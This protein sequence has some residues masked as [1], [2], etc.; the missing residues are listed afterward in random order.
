MTVA[1]R[2]AAY[3]DAA[4]TGVELPVAV[5]EDVVRAYEREVSEWSR[6]AMERAAA[7]ARARREAEQQ[8]AALDRQRQRGEGQ[9]QQQHARGRGKKRGGGGKRGGRRRSSSSA[10]P[11]SSEGLATAATATAALAALA[12]LALPDDAPA[13][14]APS[15]P[16][17]MPRDP[18]FARLYLAR[19]ARG[20]VDRVFVDHPLYGASPVDDRSPD[21]VYTY[22]E[23]GEGVGMVAGS[24]GAPDL[25]A[26]YS[27]LCQA[28]LAAPL[29]LWPRGASGGA[30]ASYSDSLH[31]VPGLT[32][33]ESATLRALLG[34]RAP[35]EARRDAH[36]PSPELP[37]RVV[38][39]LV[40]VQQQQQEAFEEE[41]ARAA[42]PDTRARV[43]AALLDAKAAAR[44]RDAALR[45]AAA[46][47]AAAAAADEDDNEPPRQ[48]SASPVPTPAP[49]PEG[50]PDGYDPR[51]V[52]V[53][54][55][56]P[57]GPLPHW[58][59]AYREEAAAAAAPAA[60]VAAAAAAPDDDAGPIVPPPPS[61]PAAAAAAS[62]D[63]PS[64]GGVLA[65]ATMTTT[66]TAAPQ[67]AQQQQQQQQPPPRR[68]APTTADASAAA[69][70]AAAAAAATTAATP[71][72][73]DPVIAAAPAVGSAKAAGVPL[74]QP[75]LQQQQQQQPEQPQQPQQQQQQQSSPTAATEQAAD[76]LLAATS[77]YA[78]SVFDPR[79]AS[80]VRATL[81][82]GESSTSSQAAAPAPASPAAAASQQQQQQQQ[83][84]LLRRQLA[85]DAAEAAELAAAEAELGEAMARLRS[86][87]RPPPRAPSPA[88]AEDD[89]GE[90]QAASAGASGDDAPPA[91]E[92]A[93]PAAAAPASPPPPPPPPP[94]QAVQ[95]LFGRLLSGA[96]VVMTVHNGGYQGDFG[97]GPA[98]DVRRLG[99]PD[100]AAPAFGDRPSSDSDGAKGADDP[101]AN[102]QRALGRAMDAFR[103]AVRGLV[104][105]PAAA[106]VEEEEPTAAAA[107]E[108]EDEQQ[109]QQQAEAPPPAPAPR[110]VNWLRG[111]LV[112]GDAVVTVSPE[113]AREMAGLG[114]EAA[115]AG[116]AAAA[117]SDRVG[118]SGL[119]RDLAAALRARGVAGIL[120]GLDAEA[121]DPSTDPLLPAAARFSP[122]TAAAGKAAAKQLLRRRLGLAG[123]EE[124]KGDLA[125]S[126][127]PLVAYV[128]R[129]ESQK[130]VD[131][132]LAALPAL[133][134]DG[135]ASGEG[136]GAGSS[137]STSTSTSAATP[138]NAAPPPSLQLVML[139]R[140]QPWMERV[141]ASLARRYPGKAAGLA[142]FSEPLA[143]LVLAAADFVVVP[144]RFEPCG[145]VAL[146]AL[147]YGCPVVA[148]RTGGLVD[149]VTPEVGYPFD[150]PPSA[151]GQQ[152]E[153]AQEAGAAPDFRRAVAALASSVTGAVAEYGTDAYSSRRAAGMARAVSW[154][155]GPALQWEALLADVLSSSSSA[156]AEG[157]PAAAPPLADDE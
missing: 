36:R 157:G 99:L 126:S 46:S 149:I 10:S 54:N 12:A 33:D 120:N 118:P 3:A 35:G 112:A 103:G 91:A 129:F 114:S 43:L 95:R 121:W 62:P 28:A 152:Q 110:G 80:M 134:G 102:A 78:V 84:L 63:R 5:P 108:E 81:A 96:R 105:G 32:D 57:C 145:L 107:K 55:D 59:D 138:T 20:R 8:E 24:G 115:A 77:D 124:E 85:A 60:P 21:R 123:G 26:A 101:L 125:S 140:G 100:K 74:S 37:L 133:L 61:T 92:P 72:L 106:E 97:T 25:A 127:V 69:A 75:P 150:A 88:P 132:L 148:A 117:S 66:T 143:H 19:D 53:G 71:E 137:S 151:A 82:E 131:V 52:F 38:D 34:G 76:A 156:A 23:A 6:G 68:A 44:R 70:N 116:W 42:S 17:P 155:E 18:R 153:S 11:S 50:E 9:Q 83:Q 94:L 51:I 111:G 135:A 65:A 2:Y 40:V 73:D 64:D 139:G 29:L 141:V 86:L 30:S 122:E 147:R 1:P 142:E 45:L 130:G 146:A 47:P 128:G 39:G 22:L 154:Q 104:G 79:L 113:Y 4:D 144:S 49:P 13:A 136:G 67:K 14:A 90:A 87:L 15:P 119:P 48:R 58:L 16:P 98:G 89:E 27:V 31:Q 109:P 93:E 7:A 56:W 41:Q